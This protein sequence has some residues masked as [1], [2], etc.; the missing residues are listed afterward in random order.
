M[1]INKLTSTNV[2]I[3]KTVEITP[4]NNLVIISGKNGQGKSS[5]IDTI[6]LALKG[7][8][9]EKIDP[10][11]IIRSGEKEAKVEL[12]LG[13]YLVTRTFTKKDDYLKVTIKD[14]GKGSQSLLNELMGDLAKEGL[15]F[16]PLA[17]IDLDGKKQLSIF[18]KALG[19][20]A[21]KIEKERKQIFDERTDVNRRIRD[22]EG[23]LK[24]FSAIDYSKVPDVELSS[25]GIVQ[26]IN[27]ATII[28]RENDK[29][30]EELKSLY[31]KLIQKHELREALQ[32]QIEELTKKLNVL[33]NDLA[34]GKEEYLK[35]K[36]AIES[37]MDP[38][39]E[40]LQKQLNNAD[41]INKQVRE[42]LSYKNLQEKLGS[43][44]ADSE[45]LTA[46]LENIDQK[47]VDAIKSVNIPLPGLS[48][49]E[50]GLTLNNIPFKSSLIST[51]EALKVGIA[52]AM[53]FNPEL[54]V[55]RIQNGN[56]LDDESLARLEEILKATGWQAWIEIVDQSG[57]KGIVIENG[58]IKKVNQKDLAA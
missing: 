30:R 27:A 33:E 16:D 50:D 25:N 46:K 36:A 56:L 26:S 42:K 52:V 53:A 35:S 45:N 22:L 51:S 44:Q 5:A 47:K 9:G 29:R 2:K 12:D 20:D 7:L 6:W 15:L 38:D 28:I 37:L 3:L 10:A 39:I 54:K 48:F 40:D 41:A 21:E 24:Q 1:I 32:T 11:D 43:A 13:K 34:T 49:N 8:A 57:E 58:E 19:I 31:T 4:E 23:Q 18:M 14:G 55:I 17:F